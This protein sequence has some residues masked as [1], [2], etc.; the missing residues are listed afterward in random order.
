LMQWAGGEAVWSYGGV[1]TVIADAIK[2]RVMVRRCNR[3]VA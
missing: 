3:Q 2:R 1:R